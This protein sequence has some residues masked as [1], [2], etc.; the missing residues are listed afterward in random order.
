VKDPMQQGINIGMM[1]GTY[2]MGVIAER[3]YPMTESMGRTLKERSVA[4]LIDAV[5]EEGT[6]G[7]LKMVQP[8]IDESLEF[9][10]QQGEL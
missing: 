1:L 4:D 7:L 3:G 10:K 8:Y 6:P 9:I 5:G 2:I